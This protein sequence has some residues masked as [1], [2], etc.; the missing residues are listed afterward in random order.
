MVVTGKGPS[1]L[2]RVWLKHLRLAW[3]TISHVQ[4]TTLHQILDQ[5]VDVFKPE[6]DTLQGHEASI[7]EYPM[8]PP[9][10]C[11]TRSVPYALRPKVDQE[12]DRLVAVG[13]LEPVRFS[14]WTAPIVPVLKSDK[15]TIHMWGF[16]RNSQYHLKG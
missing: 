3:P 15:E 6:L 8:V 2:G 13:V 9:K 11:K 10:F 16:Q 5:H 14:E 12:L 7:H 1:L 4:S